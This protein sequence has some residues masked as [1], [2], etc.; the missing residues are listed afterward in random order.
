MKLAEELITKARQAL[1][2]GQPLEADLYHRAA[3]Q[4]AQDEALITRELSPA[5]TAER[6]LRVKAEKR[7]ADA[8]HD[9]SFVPCPASNGGP[10]AKCNCWKSEETS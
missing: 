6:A 2:A 5:L 4:V 8:P 1:L 7:I 10:E 9:D 3:T